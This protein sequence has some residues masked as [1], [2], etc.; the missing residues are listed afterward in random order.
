MKKILLTALCL[1]ILCCGCAPHKPSPE[2][3]LL[4][5][6]TETVNQ[7]AHA[8]D[9]TLLL[10]RSY[11]R[12]SVQGSHAADINRDLQNRIA[13]WITVSD[14]LERYAQSEYTE[15][16]NWTT[17]F[18]KLDGHTKRLDARVFSLYFEYSEFTGGNHPNLATYCITYDCVSG[19]ALELSDLLDHSPVV[20]TGL[21]N[22]AL[23]SQA[24]NLYDDYEALVGKT[25]SAGTMEWSLS[26]DGLCFHFAPY[27]IAPYSSGIIS[28]T[29]TYEQLS[30]IIL[31]EY[32]P[33]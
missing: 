1:C 21:V 22:A 15:G 9:G 31:P 14:D 19:K 26:D 18:A 10:E 24:E 28:A 12:F 30:G 23:S 11:P 6:S 13:N 33:A 29:V 32:L 5:V 27:A 2:A 17:W 16:E 25:F 8:E 20:L 7:K 3:V 4:T